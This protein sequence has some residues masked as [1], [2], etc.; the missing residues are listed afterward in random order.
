MSWSRVILV[1]ITAL[2][3]VLVG[4]VAP[5]RAGQQTTP[6]QTYLV[7]PEADQPAD[8][9]GQGYFTLTEAPGQSPTVRVA[10]KNP[11]AAPLRLLTYPVDAYQLE[12]S[13]ID[14]TTRGRELRGVGAWLTVD[15][16]E[17][18]IPPGETARITAA[19][20]VPPTLAAGQYV[21]GIAIENAEVQR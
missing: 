15:P 9:I 11:G 16:P 20:Q 19:V 14:F 1:G 21:G 8:L 18:T 10:V 3:T 12:D 17:L 7:Q 5:A 4:S 2:T 6:P 13:G